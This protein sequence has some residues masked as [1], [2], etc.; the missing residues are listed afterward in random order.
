[1]HWSKCPRKIHERHP[2]KQEKLSDYE[3]IALF[4]E[5]SA[6]IKRKLPQKLK[7][8]RSF[9]ISCSIDNSIFEKALCDLG[10]NINLMPLFILRKLGLG[11]AN[12]TTITL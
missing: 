11:K 6:I 9:N 10:A 7:D 4:E 2:S 1:M 12:S 5:Y 3:T 8:P